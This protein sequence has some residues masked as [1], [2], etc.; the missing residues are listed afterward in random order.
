MAVDHLSSQQRILDNLSA[1]T[2][3]FVAFD[4]SEIEQS[5][6]HPFEQQV[7]RDPDRIAVEARGCALTYDALNRAANRLAWAILA[8]CGKGNEP[9]ALLFDHSA[10]MIVAILG[11]LK[12]GK[13]YVPLDPTYPRAR[14]AYMLEDAQ[15]VLV[16]THSRNLPLARD[17]AGQEASLINLDELDTA[18]SDSNLDLPLGPD[19]LAYILYTSGST[20]QPK[21]IVNNHRN[22]LHQVMTYTN[23]IC[24]GWDDRHSQLQS[25]SFSRTLKEVFGCLLN[26]ATLCMHDLREEGLLPLA[27]WLIE[28]EITVLGSA[29]TT[30]RHFVA[31]LTGVETFPN[32]RLLYLG[33]EPLYRRDVELYQQH[34]DPQCILVHGIGATETG[35]FLRFFMDKETKIYGSVV[36]VGY[37]VQDMD[38]RL[39]DAQGKPIGPDQEGEV[40]V[41]SRYLARGYWRRPRLT[42]AAFGV[43]QLDDDVLV[44]RTGDLGRMGSDGCIK[45]LGR[46]DSQVKVRGHRIEVAEIE[47]ALLAHPQI[48]EAAVVALEERPSELALA[49]YV[50]PKG[51]SAPGSHELRAWLGSRYPAYMIPSVGVVL[52][53]LPLTPSGK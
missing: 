40:T 21:G 4:K 5:I 33:A 18:L 36:P 52:D 42:R 17:L 48:E 30:F 26:G 7:R 24:L 14:L 47:M 9:L 32:L 46:N 39:L 27:E 28:S 44:Y 50:V 43:E 12:A 35:T 51:A 37:P 29:V 15:A 22:L 34:F 6:P 13:I 10:S 45:L 11:A 20:G 23:S 1:R 19:T 49:A 25:C 8:R 31:T 2:G 16:V 41:R 53:A 3:S 38:V